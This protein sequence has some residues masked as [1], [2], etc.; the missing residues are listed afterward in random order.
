M[1][2]PTIHLDMPRLVERVQAAARMIQGKTYQFRRLET[3]A[4]AQYN[5]RSGW[6]IPLVNGDD[7]Y[8]AVELVPCDADEPGAV[9]IHRHHDANQARLDAEVLFDLWAEMLPDNVTR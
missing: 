8:F 9:A 1:A 6:M 3:R 5:P 7:T 4:R 2:D